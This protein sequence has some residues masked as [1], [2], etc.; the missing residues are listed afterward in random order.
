[1]F[2]CKFWFRAKFTKKYF[3]PAL[4]LMKNKKAFTLIELLVVIAII[5]ILAT[6]SVIALSNAR[7]KARDTK[8]VADIKQVQTALE[9]FFNDKGRYPTTA[10]FNVGSLFST[11][12]LGTTTYMTAIPSAATPPDGS[13]SSSTNPFGYTGS[14]DGSSYTLSFCLGGNTGSLAAGAACAT[15]MGMTNTNCVPA[16]PASAFTPASISSLKLWLDASRGITKDGSNNV[17]A[18]ADQSSNGNNATQGTLAI[19][20]L[21][22][23]DFGEPSVRFNTGLYMA[24]PRLTLTNASIFIVYRYTSPTYYPLLWDTNNT[25]NGEGLTL[26]YSGSTNYFYYQNTSSGQGCLPDIYTNTRLL[27]VVASNSATNIYFMGVQQASADS[28]GTNPITTHFQ[29]IG[30]PSEVNGVDV[31]EMLIYDQPLSNADRVNVEN[32]LNGKHLFNQIPVMTSNTAP[33]G[34][35]SASSN[36]SHYYPYQA[37]CNGCGF[38]DAEPITYPQWL[39]YQFP[40]ATIIKSYY[41]KSRNLGSNV[42]DWTLQGSNDNTNWSN[43][44]TRSGQ[45]TNVGAGSFYHFTNSTAYLYYKINVTAGESSNEIDLTDFKLFSN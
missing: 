33:S 45:A 4:S 35:V 41:L 30:N 15:P 26:R 36:Y 31:M 10:E 1:M 6:I 32:Y 34:V 25:M 13:C 28:W 22:N 9:L 19:E 18:W 8:R 44:D 17:S 23:N 37:M 38:W 27:S 39:E 11:S 5:G 14:T 20:P 21:F 29:H 24:F 2:F 12:T 7:S 16:A 40:T 3:R 43:L 42:R